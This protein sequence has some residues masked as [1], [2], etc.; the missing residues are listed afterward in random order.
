[1]NTNNNPTSLRIVAGLFVFSGICSVIEVVVGLL[2]SHINLN[3]GVLC[4]WIGPSAGHRGHIVTNNILP[5]MR[6][7]DWVEEWQDP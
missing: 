6:R 3:L 2:H 4:L 5:G 7:Y 1:M